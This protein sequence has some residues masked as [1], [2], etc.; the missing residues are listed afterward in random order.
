M[1]TAVEL[2]MLRSADPNAVLPGIDAPVGNPLPSSSLIT[3][4]T[5]PTAWNA[6][7]LLYNPTTNHV[8][9]IQSNITISGID[10]GDA[11]LVLANNVTNVT[12][13]DCS[14]TSP[15]GYFSVQQSAGAANLTVES[16]TF[17]G[18]TT[19]SALSGVFISS[20]DSITIRNSSFVNS[21]STALAVTSG[22][23]ITGNYIEGGG[24]N[25]ASGAHANGITVRSGSNDVISGNF[26][27][28]TKNADQ[29][30]PP[31]GPAV[32]TEAL[33]ADSHN[34]T[35]SGNYLIGGSYTVDVGN[36]IAS[37]HTF[38]NNVVSNNYVG[39]GVYGAFMTTSNISG[40]SFAGN[41]V[42]DFTNAS[43]STSAWTAYLQA[44]GVKTANLIASS[45]GT[46][47]GAAT[48]ATTL[49]G[50][51]NAG[52]SLAGAKNETV[53]V[54]GAGTQYVRG[55]LGANIVT[56]LAVSDSTNAQYDIVQAFDAAKDVIDLGRIDANPLQAGLQNFT[57]IGS[58]AFSGSGPQVRIQQD[59]ANNCTYVQADL[60]GDAGNSVPDIVI[61]LYG[62][63]NLTAANFAL[64]VAQST[65][66]LANGAGLT[67][68]T[69]RSG[70]A[71]EYDYSNVHGRSYTSYSAFYSTG[72]VIAADN[73]NLSATSNELDLS[74]S[75]LTV[76]RGSGAETLQIGTS[77]FALGYHA[78]ETIQAGAAGADTFV[79]GQNFGSETINGFGVSGT[80]ADTLQLSTASFAYL[81][82]G[83]T[84]AQDLAAVLAHATTTSDGGTLIVDSVGDTLALNGLAKTTI[85]A[86]PSQFHFA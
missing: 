78:S 14:F 76:T 32:V 6:A 40:V 48:G 49:Y 71:M 50:A 47:A 64:T 35:V 25:I 10:F 46:V 74:A 23:V 61:K 81:T 68:A 27:D 51:G 75:G 1:I 70:S 8:V 19:P 42:V 2:Q 72:G 15:S 83:M 80:G 21:P 77:L 9:V 34:V 26:I 63:P 79:L 22:A 52:I 37:G 29:T 67:Y 31:L 45:G 56:E 53:Y 13:K 4:K 36:R 3:Y 41:S 39:F 38:A 65:A 17:K 58:A 20:L 24:Y 18:S 55:G 69:V 11:T 54:G 5:L 73:L 33:T 12:V 62:L 59:V 44:G 86:N 7:P 84:Q 66:A 28:W 43:S 82:A 60:A 16:C 30:N 57:F 85:A